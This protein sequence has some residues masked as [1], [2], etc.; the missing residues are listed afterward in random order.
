M[1]D[2]VLVTGAGGF[3]GSAI[4]RCLLDADFSVRALVRPDSRRENLDGL[5]I[6]FTTGDIRDRASLDRAMQDCGGVFHAAA[7]YRM[8]ARHPSEIYVTNVRGSRNVVLAAARAGVQRM[9]Y[10]SSVATLGLQED[11]APADEEA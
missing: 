11:G 10:T 2:T 1:S 9:V 4:V 7:D 5:D 8:W 6:E 3:V